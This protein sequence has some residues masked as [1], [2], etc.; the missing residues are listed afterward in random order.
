MQQ[1]GVAEEFRAVDIWVCRF[2]SAQAAEAYFEETYAEELEDAEEPEDDDR[3]ISQFAGDMGQVSYDHDFMER[4]EFREP[5][6]SDLGAALA[7][8]SYAASYLAKAVEA[9]GAGPSVP[10]NAVLLV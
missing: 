6:V 2:P 10:F 4:G 7:G 9:F 5:P 8:H 3:P 1:D